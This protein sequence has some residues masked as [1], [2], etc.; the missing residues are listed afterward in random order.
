MGKNWKENK[1]KFY[2]Y[3]F[4]GVKKPIIME[5]YDRKQ[6][7]K[8]LSML[9]EKTGVDINMTRL[10]DVKIE[11]PITG[12]SKRIR[13]GNT[14]IWVGTKFTSDG[15]MLESEFLKKAKK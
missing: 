7:N 13:F 3:Y 6:A 14:H 4:L 12:I 1:I 9:P 10:E 15:W 2:K 11:M 8:M 5:A